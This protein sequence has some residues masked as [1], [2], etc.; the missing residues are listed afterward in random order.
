MTIQQL[1]IF[2]EVCR[3]GSL[4]RAA[5][6][7]FISQ[8]G[9]SSAISRLEKEYSCRLLIRSAKGVVPTEEGRFLLSQSE[10]ILKAN[11]D[12]ARYFASHRPVQ[13][14]RIASTFGA[15]PEFAEAALNRFAVQNPGV[16]L[17]ISEFPDVMC[18]DAVESGRA[19]AG[20]SV[21]PVD[22]DKFRA[23][24]LFSSRMC[25]L[26]N[27]G[28]CFSGRESLSVA[29]LDRR[30]MVIPNNSFKPPRRFL[31]FCAEQ[32]AEPNIRRRVG[33]IFTIH[34]LVLTH[35]GYIGLTVESV[36]QSDP[37]PNLI[38][39]PFADFRLEWTVCLIRRKE[40]T[41]PLLERLEK[42]LTAET[43]P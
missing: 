33:E 6:K 23:V 32:G 36:V 40:E 18:D 20:F 39:L 24:K 35:P 43:L 28:H 37:N 16:K 29:E 15:L 42:S 1:L 41:A 22:E 8:Q 30:D 4:S 17:E 34:R 12:C 3:S 14:L 13:Q 27:S 19:D 7:L 25:L 26:V 21:W 2:R 10:V 38:P 5:K 31:E 9:L 11:D